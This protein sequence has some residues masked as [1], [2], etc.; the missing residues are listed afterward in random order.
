MGIGPTFNK[1]L[2]KQFQIENDGSIK[3]GGRIGWYRIRGLINLFLLLKRERI[4][5]RI[6]ESGWKFKGILFQFVSFKLE[7]KFIC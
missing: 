4:R 2:I 7:K 5:S 1:S 3:H 6:M